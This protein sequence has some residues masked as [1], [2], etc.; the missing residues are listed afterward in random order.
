MREPIFADPDRFG[1]QTFDIASDAVSGKQLETLFSE[2][3]GRPIPYARFSDEVLAA[4]PF[5]AKLTALMDDGTL[6][7][8]ADLKALRSLHPRMQSVREWLAH[9]GRD[10]FH[11]AL[12]T[13][14]TWAYDR[15]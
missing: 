12:G 14:G 1:G 13:T 11:Q 7:G 9:T 5:L 6:A 15:R 2:A 10:A 3:A 8:R 4:S